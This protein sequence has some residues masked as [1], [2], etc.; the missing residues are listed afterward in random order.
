MAPLRPVDFGIGLAQIHRR[1]RRNPRVGFVRIATQ[2]LRVGQQCH[3]F[4]VRPIQ[5]VV[6][7]SDG[8]LL[9]PERSCDVVAMAVGKITHE[10]TS[11]GSLTD[12][13]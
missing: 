9:R 4:G 2:Q 11:L 12:C 5:R 6:T 1:H 10:Q 8:P 13:H 3:L 7:K